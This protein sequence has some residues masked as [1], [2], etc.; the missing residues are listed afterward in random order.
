MPAYRDLA[1]PPLPVTKRLVDTTLGLPMYR[2]LGVAETDRITRALEA[3][4]VEVY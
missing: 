2:G 1:S 3:A 4:S